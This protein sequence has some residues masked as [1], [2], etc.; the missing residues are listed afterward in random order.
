MRLSLTIISVGMMR[1][2]W[3]LAFS[4]V[5]FPQVRPAVMPEISTSNLPVNLPAQPIGPN[6]LIS[7][8][9]YDAPEFTRA[10]RVGADGQIRFPM[11]KS[12]I[13]ALGSLPSDLETSIAEAL[14]VEDLIVDPFVTVEVV[15]Y[16]SRPINVTGAV[17]RPLT[18]QAA[19]PVTLLD[20]I[21]RAEGLTLEAGP[22]ILVSRLDPDPSNVNAR[23]VQRIP[24]KELME[25]SDP[26]LNLKLEGGEEIRVPE[27]GKVF[28]LGNVHKPGAFAVQE[29]SET[30]VLKMLALSEGLMPFASRKAYIYRREDTTGPKNEIAIELKKIMDRKAPDVA[31]M[32]NDI[33]YIPDNSGRRTTMMAIERALAFGS[34]AG[35]TALIYK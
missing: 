2:L 18:F 12:K 33:L 3:V 24:V 14:A 15:E 20:A 25:A 4:S 32:A 28:V 19:G 31:L 21:A 1:T 11:L 29:A 17:R 27:V 22:E 30:T 6:D 16:A 13:K 10:V 8:S 35:A 5:A 7:V 23:T 34:T 26:N 9:V